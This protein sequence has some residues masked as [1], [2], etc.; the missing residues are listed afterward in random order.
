MKAE[1]CVDYL[2]HQWNT[3]ELI[4]TYRETFKQRQKFIVDSTTT[5]TCFLLKNENKLKKSEEYKLKRFQNALW[6]NMARNCTNHLGKANEL[7]NPATVSWQKESDITWLY[8]PMYTNSSNE[9][10]NNYDTQS[11]LQGL[12]PVLKKQSNVTQ[13]LPSYSEHSILFYAIDTSTSTTFT[14]TTASVWS[15]YADSSV[16]TS[17]LCSSRSSFSSVSSK[18]SNH[19]IGVHF[20][21]EII[22]IEYQPEYPVSLESSPQSFAYY[23]EQEEDEED[24]LWPLLIQASESL[25]ASTYTRI[26]SLFSKCL[27]LYTQQQQKHHHSSSSSSPT[28][29]ASSSSLQLFILMVSMMKSVVSLTTTWLLYQSLSPLSSWLSVTAKPTV[30]NTAGQ[31][32]KQS[33]KARLIL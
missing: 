16:T 28:R 3:D 12:K 13:S 21:P 7:I 17:A 31:S 2:S 32:S 19:S 25:K 11:P 15:E 14:T 29:Y 33:N 23:Q 27:Y 1:Y 24:T 26:S 8:G 6:R 10:K 4:A 9:K 30:S 5:T 22:E 20:N 18:S